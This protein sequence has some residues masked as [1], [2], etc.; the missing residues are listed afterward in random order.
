MVSVPKRR[1]VTALATA[2]LT[3]GALFGPT[4]AEA[5]SAPSLALDS[6]A[7]LSTDVVIN[8]NVTFSGGIPVGGWYS[9][10]VFGSGSYTYSGH[11]HNSGV[12]GYNFAGV[13]VVRFANGT[14][15]VFVTSGRVHGTFESGSR[16]HN[17]NRSAT[18][19]SIRDAY[20]ASG[21]GWNA[22]CRN[23]IDGDRNAL[24]NST[25]Q[26]AGYAKKVIVI[27]A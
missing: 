3:T 9:L 17:W 16:D 21:G 5:A 11:M 7:I 15:F 14:A 8:R 27:F 20:Q 4:V 13:C 26:G 1:G 6:L 22:R 25:I 10:S 12:Q 24:I 18:R 2:L 19:Q 23:Q